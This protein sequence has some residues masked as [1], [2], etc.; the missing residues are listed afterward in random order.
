MVKVTEG[1]ESNIRMGKSCW[2][3]VTGSQVL[4]GHAV[5]E[6][7]EALQE[8]LIICL[9]W[10][11]AKYLLSHHSGP[12]VTCAGKILLPEKRKMRDGSYFPGQGGGYRFLYPRHGMEE[13][14]GQA[15]GFRHSQ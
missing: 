7:I 6:E 9:I 1:G 15:V 13:Q 3:D 10:I 2:I 5:L 4:T 11:P 12:S 8:M 14:A